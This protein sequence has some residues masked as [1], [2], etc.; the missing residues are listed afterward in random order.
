MKQWYALHVSLY[1][2]EFVIRPDCFVGHSCPGGI[3]PESGPMSLD[4]QHY[5]HAGF[6]TGDWHLAY[7]FSLIY[8]S[9]EVSLVGVFPHF[10]STSRNP[11]RWLPPSRKKQNR[12]GGDTVAHLRQVRGHLNWRMGLPALLGAMPH[13]PMPVNLLW[14]GESALAR[15]WQQPPSDLQDIR[16]T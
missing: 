12:V 7:M 13:N 10:V 16:V 11:S 14:V 3:Y 2:Y 9:V 6:P 8:F 4:I 1:S 15:E 5:Y